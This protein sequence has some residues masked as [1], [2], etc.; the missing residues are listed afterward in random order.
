M[1]WADGA[2]TLSASTKAPKESCCRD[3]TNLSQN[4]HGILE[5]STFHEMIC[6]NTI[7]INLMYINFNVSEKDVFI[8]L[9][10]LHG[11]MCSVLQQLAVAV[12]ATRSTTRDLSTTILFGQLWDRLEVLC[13]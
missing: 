11:F 10:L 4:S 9:P 8:K 13:F 3:S 2:R 1:A 6:I 7:L 5:Y 12:V